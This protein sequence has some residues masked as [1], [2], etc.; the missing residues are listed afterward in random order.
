MT[1]REVFNDI[2][3]TSALTARIG[4]L[5]AELAKANK[6]LVSA[7]IIIRDRMIPECCAN[8]CHE[9]RDFF[10]E[11]LGEPGENERRRDDCPY[12]IFEVAK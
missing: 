2:A 4:D 10:C 8:C 6:R 7:N 11:L 5:E 1:P 3:K 9:G 12:S